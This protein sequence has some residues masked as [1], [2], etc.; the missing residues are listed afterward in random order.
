MSVFLSLTEKGGG[1]VGWGT[2]YKGAWYVGG[3]KKKKRVERDKGGGTAD[4]T[5]TTSLCNSLTVSN[6]GGGGCK[7]G[8]CKSSTLMLA[9]RWPPP[10]SLVLTGVRR[11]ISALSWCWSSPSGR[12][13][14]RGDWEA[15]STESVSAQDFRKMALVTFCNECG[16]Q[17]ATHRLE[18]GLA[19]NCAKEKHGIVGDQRTINY[20]THL[21]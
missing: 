9:A 2:G 18:S 11:P 7:Q 15:G 3:Q 1:G 14:L 5:S 21:K 4:H 10:G 12:K 13:L 16:K 17:C 20:T 19:K 8:C 6:G